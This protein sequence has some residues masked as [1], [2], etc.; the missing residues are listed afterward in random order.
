MSEKDKDEKIY[1]PVLSQVWL[2]KV[3]GECITLLKRNFASE[4][5][6]KNFC[7][8]AFL[9]LCTLFE[10]KETRVLKA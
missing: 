6:R 9:L 8:K 3:D 4:F 2:L 1:S 5:R 7:K 10:I